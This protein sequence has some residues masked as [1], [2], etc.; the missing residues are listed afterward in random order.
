MC[1]STM[2]SG[3]L[4]PCAA[5]ELQILLS[6]HNHISGDKT[7]ETTYPRRCMMSPLTG[8]HVA[9]LATDG[10]EES[11]L[12]EPVKALWDAGAAV[13]ILAPKMGDIQGMRH[14][15]EKTLKVP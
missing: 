8:F 7:K 6:E 15:R 11:E 5:Q 10:F 12:K 4:R 13:T 3:A 9:V 2:N 14:D 1:A